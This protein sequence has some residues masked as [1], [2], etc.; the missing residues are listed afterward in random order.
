MA[1][2]D[3]TEVFDAF[4]TAR[5]LDAIVCVVVWENLSDVAVESRHGRHPTS[6]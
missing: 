6:K 3:F 1:D 4:F 5:Y 2:N